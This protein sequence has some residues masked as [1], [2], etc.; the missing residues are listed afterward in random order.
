METNEYKELQSYKTRVGFGLILLL[1]SYALISFSAVL[2][3]IELPLRFT[4]KE[5]IAAVILIGLIELICDFGEKNER[6][7]IIVIDSLPQSGTIIKH[8]IYIISVFLAY[9]AY[10]DL[11]LPY[12]GT[13]S[14][15]YPLVFGI[16]FFYLVFDIYQNIHRQSEV[17][18]STEAEVH[19]PEDNIK[20]SGA[21]KNISQI[22]KKTNEHIKDNLK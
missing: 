7:H 1:G 16:I 2:E 14:W 21:R 19:K 5:L 22:N 18:A 3:Q 11:V 13:Y 10:R 17:S 8:G 15:V 20:E 12:L 9:S 4:F 6:H